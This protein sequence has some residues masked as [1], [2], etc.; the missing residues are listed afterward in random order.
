MDFGRK[1]SASA[2]IRF[3]QDVMTQCAIGI[4]YMAPEADVEGLALLI[5]GKPVT[6]VTLTRTNEG[7][8]NIFHQFIELNNGENTIALTTKNQSKGDCL[9]DNIILTPVSQN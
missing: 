6:D 9:I 5:N 3:R 2:R 7:E 8:W 1:S 4:K